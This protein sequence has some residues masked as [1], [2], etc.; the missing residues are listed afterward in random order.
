MDGENIPDTLFSEFSDAKSPLDV[1]TEV[2]CDAT[3]AYIIAID[4][5]IGVPTEEITSAAKYVNDEALAMAAAAKSLAREL[6]ADNPET[7]IDKII[8]NITANREAQRRNIAEL[9]S[10]ALLERHESQIESALEE[11]VPLY[12]E[13]S[14]VEAYSLATQEVVLSNALQLIKELNK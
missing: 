8:R 7:A 10:V 12:P 1:A 9:L 13:E 6:F 2:F 5:S 11:K 14:E 4:T 3:D